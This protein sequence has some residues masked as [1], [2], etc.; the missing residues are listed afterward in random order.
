[1]ETIKIDP[2]R[3]KKRKPKDKNL[4]SAL[5]LITEEVW[6]YCGKDKPF[7]FYLGLIKRIGADRARYILGNLKDRQTPAETPG[8]LFVWMIKNNK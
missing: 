8:K 7:G 3:F 5:H 2:D 1:M 6:I 4:H